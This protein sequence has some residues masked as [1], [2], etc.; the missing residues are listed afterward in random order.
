MTEIR[1]SR[2][3]TVEQ[4]R[5]KLAYDMALPSKEYRAGVRQLAPMIVNNGLLQTLAYFRVKRTDVYNS[6]MEY[7]DKWL[8]DH[9]LEPG[10][11]FIQR[12]AE[13]TMADYRAATAEALAFAIWLKR[14]AEAKVIDSDQPMPG[15][16]QTGDQTSET[17][18]YGGNDV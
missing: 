15:V 10:K 8:N 2:L 1:L 17:A 5:A 6:V 11:E 16:V 12:V 9:G 7:L 4:E 18:A 14:F 3:Y 13:L